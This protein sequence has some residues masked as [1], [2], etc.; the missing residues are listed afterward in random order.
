MPLGV[1]G[2]SDTFLESASHAEFTD[3]IGKVS[4]SPNVVIPVPTYYGYWPS[5]REST[6]NALSTAAAA[7]SYIAPE[8]VRHRV[9][10]AFVSDVT[11]VGG[12]ATPGR[13]FEVDSI[14]AGDTYEIDIW[15]RHTIPANL[16]W[17]LAKYLVY[18]PTTRTSNSSRRA[19]YHN[20][21]SGAEVMPAGGRFSTYQPVVRM[22]NVNFSTA[23]NSTLHTYNVTVAGHTGWTLH[24]GSDGPHKMIA[25]DGWNVSIVPNQV[26]WTR[27]TPTGWCEQV[28]VFWGQERPYIELTMGTAY[29][30]ANSLL[31]P[32]KLYYTPSGSA[33]RTSV[34]SPDL[35]T[36]NLIPAGNFNQSGSTTFDLVEWSQVRP[37]K[38]N[39]GPQEISDGRK[40]GVIPVI[41]EA[42][43]TVTVTRTTQ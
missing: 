3:S 8:Y 7:G 42:P 17:S 6:L 35:G 9:N 28:R 26:W 14:S 23:F 21:E 15:Y 41:A 16:R 5:F 24:D 10:G 37:F 25:T 39:Y 29:C 13:L 43:T 40:T 2:V 36:I 12:E 20:N 11:A 27:N 1:M 30:S 4:Q 19:V 38:V 22:Q 33:Y 32:A 31:T 18:I 34:S